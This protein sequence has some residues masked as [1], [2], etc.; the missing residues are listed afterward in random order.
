MKFLLISILSL[1]MALVAF[2][3]PGLTVQDL[4]VQR[5]YWFKKA[6]EGDVEAQYVMGDGYLNGR[7]N[8]ARDGLRAVEWFL[9]AAARGHADS[10]FELGKLYYFGL[11]GV[12]PNGQEAVRW[13]RSAEAQP[14]LKVKHRAFSQMLLATCFTTGLG[15]AKNDEEAARWFK[16]AAEGGDHLAE[17]R[18]GLCYLNGTGVPQNDREA[19]FWFLKAANAGETDAQIRLAEV[20]SNGRGVPQD[21]VAAYKWYNVAA[22]K[23]NEQAIK[24]RE[25]LRSIMTPHQVAEAQK[26]SSD[27]HSR[28]SAS[29]DPGGRVAPSMRLQ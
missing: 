10:Q 26:L 3:Q 24:S 15:V 11:S 13:L 25:L 9:K 23:G 12:E 28:A 22:A 14:G 7:M 6:M 27:Y 18:L 20:F 17:Y 19:S 1:T 16:K 21:Y 2:A 8:V 4:D 29:T 5:Q